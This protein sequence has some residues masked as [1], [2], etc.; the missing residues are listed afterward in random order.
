VLTP[1]SETW[2]VQQLLAELAR[3]REPAPEKKMIPAFARM[4]PRDGDTSV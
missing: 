4:L 3:E 1:V 2:T